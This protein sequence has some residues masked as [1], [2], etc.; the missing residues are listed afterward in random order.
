VSAAVVDGDAVATQFDVLGRG[1][2]EGEVLDD[3]DGHL[4]GVELATL[5]LGA[6]GVGGGGAD[7]GVDDGVAQLVVRLVRPRTAAEPA[8]SACRAEPDE[9]ARPVV[10]RVTHTPR[11]LALSAFDEGGHRLSG[12][13]DRANAVLVREFHGPSLRHTPPNEPGRLE[14]FPGWRESYKWGSSTRGWQREP[15]PRGDT[16]KVPPPS[17]QA[18]GHT[19]GVGDGWLSNRDDTARADR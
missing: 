1:V 16:R 3:T 15:D 5:H 13:F 17:G 18:T 19:P 2:G 4:E 8:A 6:A 10:E 9:R 7:G 11:I 12:E 14:P